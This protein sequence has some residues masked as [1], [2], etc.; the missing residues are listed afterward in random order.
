MKKVKSAFQRLVGII[1]MSVVLN[2]TT[3]SNDLTKTII[4]TGH[5]KSTHGHS[6]WQVQSRV[7]TCYQAANLYPY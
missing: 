5:N 1:A 4:V 7:D 2:G 6:L 3:Q